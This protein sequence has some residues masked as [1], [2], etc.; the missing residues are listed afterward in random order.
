MSYQHLLEKMMQEQDKFMLAI[1]A[2]QHEGKLP[3]DFAKAVAGLKV[4]EQETP[5]VLGEA[6]VATHVPDID[7]VAA[8][9]NALSLYQGM[10]SEHDQ[11]AV[12]TWMEY[13]HELINMV[14]GAHIQ[15]A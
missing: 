3:E 4:W 14:R 13:A 9:V 6:E 12:V 15:P 2:F 8:M 7:A 5:K 1:D 11:N 10:F